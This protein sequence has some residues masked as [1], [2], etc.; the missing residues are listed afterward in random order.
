MIDMEDGVLSVVSRSSIGSLFENTAYLSDTSS[1][2]G[3]GGGSGNNW[4]Q[5]Y[6]EYGVKYSGEVGEMVRREVERCGS[7]QSFFLMHST[8]GGT[9]S[10]MGSRVLEV[11]EEEY[12]EVYRFVTSVMPSSTGEEGDVVTSPYNT[13]SFGGEKAF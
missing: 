1:G 2:G 5:G 6:G 9:G 8:G 10:G 4:G 11:L 12:P 13:V 3:A 7:L